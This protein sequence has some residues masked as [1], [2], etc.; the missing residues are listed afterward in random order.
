[1][2]VRDRCVCVCQ[3]GADGRHPGKWEFPGGKVE[4]G[5]SVAAGIVRELREELDIDAEP[6]R[7]LWRSQHEYADGRAV[8]LIFVHIPRFSG[9]PRNMV[10]AD[11]RWAPIETLGDY[12]FLDADRE[13]VRRLQDGTIPIEPR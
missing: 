8:A 11:V 6:G 13:F 9:T 3:R 10:F 12:D 5:E 1:V 4:R 2:I 7:E